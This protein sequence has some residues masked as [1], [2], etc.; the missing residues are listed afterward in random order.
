MAERKGSANSTV[1][2]QVNVNLQASSSGEKA[3]QA[4]AYAFTSNGRFLSKA[5]V[6]R[7]GSA[8]LKVPGGKAAQEVRIV[9]GP[10]ISG[11]E[12]PT[13]GDLT[14]RGASQQLVRIQSG[15]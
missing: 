1:S 7:D 12:E 8:A 10:E 3:P 14:R 11:K 4:V 2:I 15:G 9:A 6:S 13:L 5:A